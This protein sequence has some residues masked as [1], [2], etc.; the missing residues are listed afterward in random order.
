MSGDDHLAHV[1]DVVGHGGFLPFDAAIEVIPR[2]T[3]AVG[4]V[5]A[6][7][8][9][10]II[11]A[12][13]D[14]AWVASHCPPDDLSAPMGPSFLEALAGQIGATPG[15]H[16]LLLAA[17]GRTGPPSLAVQSLPDA[18]DHPRVRR[19]LR[20]RRDMRVYGS[21]GADGLL[22]VG[23]GLAGRWEAAFEVAPE[24]RG[25]GLGRALAAAALH[26]IEPDQPLFMQVAVGNAASLRAVLAAGFTPV[27]AEVLFT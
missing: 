13:V 5:E 3:G 15:A 21:E 7:S 16:D 1:F 6:F 2:V 4:A 19:S 22:V 24:A 25:Q 11:A 27:G 23:R 8:G 14:P 17:L 10:H 20:Y 12:D 26:L 18:A 9:H